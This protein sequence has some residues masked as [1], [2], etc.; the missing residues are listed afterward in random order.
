MK[1]NNDKP[2]DVQSRLGLGSIQ[3]NDPPSAVGS[4]IKPDKNLRDSSTPRIEADSSYQSKSVHGMNVEELDYLTVSLLTRHHLGLVIN[5]RGAT[6]LILICFQQAIDSRPAVPGD[7][8]LVPYN[9]EKEN[10]KTRKMEET[11][12]SAS[13]EPKQKALR[14]ED[15]TVD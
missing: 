2:D 11:S 4:V 10:Q 6:C 12:L 14:G 8:Q 1:L 3:V 5:I 15:D 9:Q 7:Y 13:E